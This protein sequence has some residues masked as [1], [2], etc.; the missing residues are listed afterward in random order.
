ML[1]IKLF[2]ALMIYVAA[3]ATPTS[4]P[5]PFPDCTVYPQ[6]MDCSGGE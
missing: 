2:T 6:P 3:T 4:A 1:I 5:D